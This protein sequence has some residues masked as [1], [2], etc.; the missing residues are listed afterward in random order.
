[1]FTCSLFYPLKGR[2][3]MPLL[4]L[5]LL[6]SCSSPIVSAPQPI[7][8]IFTAT[9]VSKRPP[10]GTSFDFNL[11]GGLHIHSDGFTCTIPLSPDVVL[12]GALVLTKLYP[13]YD[14]GTLQSLENYLSASQ[15]AY[16]SN[17][18]A[19]DASYPPF[20]ANPQMFQLLSVGT[21]I[22][23]CSESVHI[24]NTGKAPIHISQISLQLT[25]DTQIDQQKYK[26]INI[27]SFPV[28][29]CKTPP[30]H[31]GGEAIYIASFGLNPGKAYATS[32]AILMCYNLDECTTPVPVIQPGD[33]TEVDIKY[34][35]S[36]L[37]PSPQ[38][39]D[40]NVTFSVEPSFTLSGPGK[41]PTVASA[42]QL[43]ETF[44][45]ASQFSCY[46]L[47]G[48]QFIQISFDQNPEVCA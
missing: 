22:G 23:G 45:L 20:S 1:M 13:T 16:Y 46:S 8:S 2:F 31:G 18:A 5:L 29:T 21:S 28:P 33:V 42:P 44:T 25:A 15:Q 4:V 37:S 10:L 17:I 34:G 14:Q 12:P 3:F 26:L 9:P 27:C 6:C 32:S 7:P 24:T 41:Q 35:P 11:A 43:E 39:T 48:Q 47:Q 19:V 40:S 36:Q 30:P 38:Y